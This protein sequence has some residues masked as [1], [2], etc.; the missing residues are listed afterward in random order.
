MGY[1][2]ADQFTLLHFAVGVLAYF[3]YF[4]FWSA[5]G[6]HFLFEVVE[7]TAMGMKF[8]N[9]Y[10]PKNGLFRWPGDKVA[11]DSLAN[12]AGDNLSFAAG[13]LLAQFLDNLSTAKGWYYKH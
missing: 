3:W 2:F 1:L 10:F 12:F 11:P 9:K 4:Q 7:N 6:L 5:F 8:L 13:Y